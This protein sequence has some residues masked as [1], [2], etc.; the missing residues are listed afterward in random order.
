MQFMEAVMSQNVPAVGFIGKA[1]RLG[2]RISLVCLFVIVG[3]VFG[4]LVLRNLFSV[5]YASVDELAR[6][7]HI[8]LVY[9]L[10]PLAFIEGLHVNIDLVTNCAPVKLKFLLDIF[11]TLMM[12]AFALI[13]LISDYQFMVRSGNVP[14]PAMQMPNY[15]FFSGAYLGMALLLLA[16][17]QRLIFQLR[18]RP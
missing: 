17:C 3:L 13:F 18:H 8:Y 1:A 6:L 11:V 2:E 12:G 5:T 4:Q 10:V 7:A 16:A 15:L 14:T 9:L